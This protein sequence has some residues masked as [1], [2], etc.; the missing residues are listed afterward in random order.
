MESRGQARGSLKPAFA[1][2]CGE[3]RPAHFSPDDISPKQKTKRIRLRANPGS[4]AQADKHRIDL[5]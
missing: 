2:S 4:S 3:V 1:F 5:I